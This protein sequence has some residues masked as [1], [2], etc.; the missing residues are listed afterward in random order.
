MDTGQA[1][2]LGVCAVRHVV[3]APGQKHG[4][5]LTRLHLRVANHAR[6]VVRILGFVIYDNVQV[7]LIKYTNVQRPFYY[8]I[9]CELSP[10]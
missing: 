1:G 9:T 6:E 8:F 7:C 4:L 3:T 10:M 2:P 5:V